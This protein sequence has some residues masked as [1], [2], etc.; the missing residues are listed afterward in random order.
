MVG[1]DRDITDGVE[2]GDDRGVPRPLRAK[3]IWTRIK[4][5]QHLDLLG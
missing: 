3:D 5:T 4:S 1:I 2:V